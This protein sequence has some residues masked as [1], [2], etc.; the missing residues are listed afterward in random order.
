MSAD[1]LGIP[2]SLAVMGGAAMPLV[3]DRILAPSHRTG[4]ENFFGSRFIFRANFIGPGGAGSAEA[5]ALRP[6]APRSAFEGGFAT[7]CTALCTLPDHAPRPGGAAS[8]DEGEPRRCLGM[9]GAPGPG[10]PGPMGRR[11]DSAGERAWFPSVSLPAA[12]GPG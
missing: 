9:G 3:E 6:V 12:R 1:F 4:R 8:W 11:Q 2:G 5:G 10:S 7:A